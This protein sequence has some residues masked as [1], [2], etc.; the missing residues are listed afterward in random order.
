MSMTDRNGPEPEA[1]RVSATTPDG[2]L[3]EVFALPA[4]LHS[5]RRNFLEEYGNVEV[6]PITIAE[7]EEGT[8]V[9]LS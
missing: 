9:E 8:G 7:F 3:I 2:N 6:T 4:S 5:T 1:F